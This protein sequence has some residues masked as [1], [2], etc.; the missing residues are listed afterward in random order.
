MKLQV[1]SS[2]IRRVRR[3]A[4]GL[5]LSAFCFLPSA[6]AQAPSATGAAPAKSTL[7]S[8]ISPKAQE[9]LN[10]AIQAL[11]GQAFLSFKTLSSRG[12]VFIIYEGSTGGFAPFVNDEEFPDK[13]RF[14]YG[15]DPPVILINNGNK[16]WEL[17]RYG[18][19]RQG[20]KRLRRW[21]MANRY[22]LEGVL[23][24]VIHEPGVLVSDEGTDFKDLLPVH[25][26]DIFDARHMEVKL[27]LQRTTFL[28]VRISYRVQDPETRDWTVFAEA[29]SDYR[30]IQG[31][32]TPM[33][34]T[35]YEDDERSAEYFLNSAEYNKEY[36]PGFFRPGR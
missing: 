15:K 19:I 35:R 21:Q 12:R 18:L 10:K 11:G 29:Y 16:G 20:S 24:R 30:E 3:I 36:P 8:R 4:F 5:L 26:L 32:Q 25:V 2:E 1:E 31:I 28:P 14:A 7:P 23:R 9:L 33:R 13:R 22:S 6:Y 34:L 27:Y 17:D